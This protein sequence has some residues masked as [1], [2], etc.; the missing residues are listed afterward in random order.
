[1]TTRAHDHD[2]DIVILG[3]GFAG[4]RAARALVKDFGDERV[5]AVEGD[6]HVGGRARVSRACAPW[7]V[8]LGPEFA[9]G[10]RN[11]LLVEFLRARGIETTTRKWPDRYYFGH[12]GAS[13]DASDA[14]A[15][16]EDAR[17][18]R[19]AFDDLR[20]VHRAFDDLEGVPRDRDVTAREWL[21]LI[22]ATERVVELAETIYANDFGA[23]LSALGMREIVEEKKRWRYGD[24]YLV[25][26]RSM[27]DV[28]KELARGVD[29]RTNWEID[30]V[31]YSSPDRVVVTRKGSS[32]TI[33]A[34]KCIVALPITALRR[35]NATNCVTF[36]PS[37]PECKIA[38][39]EAIQMGNA[40][41]LFIGFSEIFWPE[42]VF[43]V[44]CT[45]CFFPEFWITKYAA[46]SEPR[47]AK[48]AEEAAAI[49]ATVGVVTFFISGKF[50]D[51]I[52]NVQ[53]SELVNRAID[54]LDTIFKVSCKERVT[55]KKIVNWAHERF[56]QGAYTYP[57]P[58]VGASREVLAAPV[59]NML[60]F[61]GE[62]TH[63]GVNPCLH[64]AME[65]GERAARQARE[66]LFGGSIKL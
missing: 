26:D 3:A 42:D 17:E 55:T 57:S 61:A 12:L 49:A 34:K 47:E 1:M 21:T 30:C 7:D 6:A 29:V 19:R 41:K 10:D 38:A 18:A 25:L 53:E 60:F 13:F 50:A 64:G 37:L 51:A 54:Q 58:N 66:A 63:T 28:A 2:V 24:K 4:L 27:E 33:V 20:E 45:D 44:I 39:A 56:V 15:K 5:T 59:S 11:S 46:S 36:I 14:E 65:T 43:D 40:A 32:E 62:A 22:G 8:N 35:G 23:S 48:S 52:A 31:D 16:C 9:H